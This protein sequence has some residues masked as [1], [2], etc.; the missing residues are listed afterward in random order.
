MPLIAHFPALREI[1]S[2]LFL[3]FVQLIFASRHTP[4]A[5]ADNYPARRHV[6]SQS[7]IILSPHSQSA[8]FQN[9]VAIASAQ[10]EFTVYGE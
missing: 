7:F 10:F 2:S 4:H 3:L 6:P 8:D 9:A 5:W 1:S